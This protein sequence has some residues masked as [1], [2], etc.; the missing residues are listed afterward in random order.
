M[1]AQEKGAMVIL[2]R[3]NRSYKTFFSLKNKKNCCK[4]TISQEDKNMN[5]ILVTVIGSFPIYVKKTCH[6]VSGTSIMPSHVPTVG[7]IS[8]K[9]RYLL[10]N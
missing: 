10:P 3:S 6:T 4:E 9:M 2:K 7:V 8:L 1:C 5:I